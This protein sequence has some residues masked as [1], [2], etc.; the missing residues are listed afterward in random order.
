MISLGM[1]K[2]ITIH[3]FKSVANSTAK[4]PKFGAIVGSNAAGKTNLIQAIRFVRD[5]VLGETTLEAQ[6]K[7]SLIPN[8]LFNYLVK[9]NEFKL[10]TKILIGDTDEYGL[11]VKAVLVNGTVKPPTL[12]IAQES[13]Y[14]IGET[15]SLVYR[16]E[17]DVL[18]D[19]SGNNIPISVDKNKLA[20]SVY[21]QG[22]TDL[23]KNSFLNVHVVDAEIMNNPSSTAIRDSDIEKSNLAGIIVNLSHNKP[24]AFDQFQKIIRKL[25]PQF[26]S[27]IEIK[28]D[29]SATPEKEGYLI[30]LEELNLKEK[31]SMQSVSAGDLRTLFFVASCLNMDDSSTL[32]IEEIE[33]GMHPNR[34]TNLIE[35]LKTIAAKKDM[36]IIFTTH[37]PLVINNLSPKDILFVQKSEEGTSFMLLEESSQVSNISEFLKRGGKLTNFLFNNDTHL[38]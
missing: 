24:E 32:I 3:N 22:S 16:R 6:K 12:E 17:G 35:H 28:A 21:K 26:S 20:I 5:I 23:V 2:S 36:Q 1:I 27:L 19:S 37:S 25:L 29:N 15:E 18:S 11:D 4:L 9:A 34:I 7:I 30:V 33:N 14:K 10:Q 38:D 8:E 31:L 13:L